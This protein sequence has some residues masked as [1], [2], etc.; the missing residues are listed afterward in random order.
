[1]NVCTLFHGNPVIVK[2]FPEV[3]VGTHYSSQSV[4]TYLKKHPT[5]NEQTEVP[6]EILYFG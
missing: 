1:M 4:S 3:A 5:T 2:M 6:L